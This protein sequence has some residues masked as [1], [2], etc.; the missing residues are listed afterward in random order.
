MSRFT[1][2]EVFRALEIATKTLSTK[3]GSGTVA[4]ARKY[5]DF[6]GEMTGRPADSSPAPFGQQRV[7]PNPSRTVTRSTL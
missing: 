3:D 5:L 6:V 1:S 4:A 7:S 2:D